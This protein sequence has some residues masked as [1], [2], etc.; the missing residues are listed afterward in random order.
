M[1]ILKLL[2]LFLFVPISTTFCQYVDSVNC[3]IQVQDLWDLD[4]NRATIK[5]D[6]YLTLE[7]K[8]PENKEL[9]LLNGTIIK[10]DTLIDNDSLNILALRISAEL[11]THFD[12]YRFPLDSQKITIEIEPYQYI[13]DLVLIIVPNQNIL[14]NKIH[15][16]GWI[17]TGI[18]GLSK[19]NDYKIIENNAPSEYKY[20][21]LLFEISIL[22]ENR[23]KYFLKTFLP[24]LISILI[25]YIGFILHSDQFY[26]RINLALGSLFVIISNF[27]VTQRSLPNVSEFTLIEKINLVSLIIVLIT[28]LFFAITHRLKN[29]FPTLNWK[30]F[31]RCYLVI[32]TIIYFGILVILLA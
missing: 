12:Y 27:I 13:E 29:K 25:I 6:F 11:R 21:S 16:N 18:K 14:V 10:A 5:A 15:L 19:I 3:F 4:L 9:S 23:F 28:I 26:M 7:Y 22:R 8:N 2:L 17:V 1:K 31:N 20:S 32:T 30:F 24:S